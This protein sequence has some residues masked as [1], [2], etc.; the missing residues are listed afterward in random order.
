MPLG[1]SVAD[2]HHVDADPDPAL[3]LM[4]IRIL[5]FT[6]MRIRILPFTG[7]RISI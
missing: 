1:S 5:S 6:V 3:I 7:M 4:R 2:P